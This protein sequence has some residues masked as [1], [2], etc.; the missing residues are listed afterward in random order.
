MICIKKNRPDKEMVKGN[1]KIQSLNSIYLTALFPSYPL[2]TQTN[3]Y[4]Y[5]LKTLNMIPLL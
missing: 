3:V 4:F 5:L 2:H 1:T